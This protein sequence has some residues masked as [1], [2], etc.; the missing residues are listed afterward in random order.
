M[1]INVII[2]SLLSQ[3]SQTMLGECLDSVLKNSKGF[4]FHILVTTNAAQLYMSSDLTKYKKRIQILPNPTNA[5][6]S[7]LNNTAIEYHMQ[8]YDAEYFLFIN[9]DVCLAKDF[10]TQFKKIKTTSDLMTPLIFEVDGEKIDSFGIEYFT[11]GYAKDSKRIEN[12]T[13][14]ATAACLLVKTSFLREMKRQYGYYFN[15]ILHFYLE[16][17][18]FSLRAFLSGGKI[19]KCKEIVCY[20]KGSATTG[21]RSRFTMYQTY[22]NV[23][24]VILMNWPAKKLMQLLPSVLLVQGWVLLYSTFYFGPL[25]YL[26]VIV[27]TIKNLSVILRY[28]HQNLRNI[29]IK[30]VEQVFSRYAFRTYHEKVIH[31]LSL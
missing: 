30:K 23:I 11:S 27:D 25:F 20:H 13:T 14:L 7:E 6:F 15:P 31:T 29:N 18:D 22:R 28:R 24:W 10:W 4:T 5:G 3:K 16:D 2:P 8:H 1:K 9:D 19:V 12:A 21:R 26:G 17:V